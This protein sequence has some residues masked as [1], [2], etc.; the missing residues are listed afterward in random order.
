MHL[1]TERGFNKLTHCSPTS[2]KV[3][4]HSIT[5]DTEGCC[6]GTR[7]TDDMDGTISLHSTRRLDK[8]AKT[9]VTSVRRSIQTAVEINAASN[10]RATAL[11][12]VSGKCAAMYAGLHSSSK[13]QPTAVRHLM[14]IL[15]PLSETLNN[16]K[17]VVR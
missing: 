4:T 13:R 16:A 5:C 14:G 3:R 7:T 10:D 17:L 6:V 8:A 1:R 2:A 11:L 9:L 12:A 15:S